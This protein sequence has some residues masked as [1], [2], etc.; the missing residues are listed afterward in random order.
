MKIAL[1]YTEYAK[2]VTIELVRRGADAF[3]VLSGGGSPNK[4]ILWEHQLHWLVK[5]AEENIGI[6]A[7]HVKRGER[8][9][10][11]PLEV[12]TA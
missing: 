12:R 9:W 4:I 6:V 7:P 3:Y 11:I 5:D 2:P 10:S 1:D 8:L